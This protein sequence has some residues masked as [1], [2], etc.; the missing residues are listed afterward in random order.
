MIYDYVF[1]AYPKRVKA[2]CNEIVNRG[3]D[4]HF[5]IRTGVDGVNPTILSYLRRAG[6]L[7][8]NYGVESGDPD[9]LKRYQ[10]NYTIEQVKKAFEITKKSG[11]DTLAYFMIGGPGETTESVGRTFRLQ[12]LESHYLHLTY[13]IPIQK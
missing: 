9:M 1:T 13:V 10:K 3:L 11:M 2:I 6:C 7:R 8:V 12:I 5:D 4:V